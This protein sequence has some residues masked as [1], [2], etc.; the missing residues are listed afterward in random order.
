MSAK[1]KELNKLIKSA[2]CRLVTLN[3]SNVQKDKFRASFLQFDGYLD[4]FITIESLIN[5]CI[6]AS[7]IDSS[8]V[9]DDNGIDIRK[10]LELANKLLPF[11]EGEFLDDVNAILK[12]MY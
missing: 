12:Q 11:D 7:H 8:N 1:K 9:T 5:V 3:P 10:T 6:M 2:K 4:L